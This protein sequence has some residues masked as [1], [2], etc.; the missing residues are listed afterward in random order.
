MDLKSE[1]ADSSSSGPQTLEAGAS[2]LLAVRKKVV[3]EAETCC[4]S[5]WMLLIAL[6]PQPIP[7]CSV[8]VG[9]APASPFPAPGSQGSPSLSQHFSL[10]P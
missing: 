4:Q 6:W 10:L 5:L 9:K 7:G 2:V 8:A 3:D 1:P